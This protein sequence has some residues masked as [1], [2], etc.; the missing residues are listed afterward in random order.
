MEHLCLNL[1]VT[2]TFKLKGRK[3]EQDRTGQTG[4]EE[5]RR[6]G[7]GREGGKDTRRSK[8]EGEHCSK[9]QTGECG[10]NVTSMSP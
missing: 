4:K 6:E 7:G 5:E 10:L 9:L 8:K 3:A 1:S 2:P